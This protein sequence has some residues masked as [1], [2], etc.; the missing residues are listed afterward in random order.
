MIY[1]RIGPCPQTIYAIIDGQARPVYVGRTY[2]SLDERFKRHRY[3]RSAVGAWLRAE[4]HNARVIALETISERPWE[5]GVYAGDRERHWIE[6]YRAEG[7][8]LF[9]V[10]PMKVAA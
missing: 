1:R 7:F 4:G 6:R 10:W 8:R 9:N 5:T 2:A 3:A